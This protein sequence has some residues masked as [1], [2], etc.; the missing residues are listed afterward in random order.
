MN[1][2]T[3]KSTGS[4]FLLP[5]FTTKLQPARVQSPGGVRDT[6]SSTPSHRV[7][8]APRRTPQITPHPQNNHTIRIDTEL[9][10]P[11]NIPSPAAAQPFPPLLRPH[12]CTLLGRSGCTKPRE[13]RRLNTWTQA[14]KPGRRTGGRGGGEGR[15][16]PAGSRV[17]GGGSARSLREAPL[18][19]QPAPPP[20]AGRA[21]A[22]A[23]NRRSRMW[24]D[25][26]DG[27]RVHHLPLTAERHRTGGRGAPRPVSLS[28][29]SS[30]TPSSSSSSSPPPPRSSS[31]PLRAAGQ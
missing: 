26:G 31:W 15:G 10:G 9:L 8:K 13:P 28:P 27:I 14:G 12:P 1:L 21:R 24:E 25:G 29:A 17:R 30:P 23:A 19:A 16:G 22:P 3:M 5:R 2:R 6:T 4:H 7:Q 20:A 11:G 18:A